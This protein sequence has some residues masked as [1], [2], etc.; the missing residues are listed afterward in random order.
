MSPV[1]QVLPSFRTGY[2]GHHTVLSRTVPPRGRH[3]QGVPWGI[4]RRFLPGVLSDGLSEGPV[5]RC[6]CWACQA[7]FWGPLGKGHGDRGVLLFPGRWWAG[8]WRT[9]WAPGFMWELL[10]LSHL[11]GHDARIQ[12]GGTLRRQ[13][14]A[15][16]PNAGQVSTVSAPGLLWLPFCILT[17]PK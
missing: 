3:R 8:Q 12:A 10:W 6:C 9:F 11:W 14:G 17:V 2:D 13:A 5:F 15:S 1:F 16:R 4:W 7:S